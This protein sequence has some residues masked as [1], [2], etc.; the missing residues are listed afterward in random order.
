VFHAKVNAIA[1]SCSTDKKIFQNVLS[2]CWWER[3]FADLA[4]DHMAQKSRLR[5]HANK[6]VAR[7][8]SRTH[9]IDS[10]GHD[11]H[12]SRFMS[13]RPNPSTWQI[14]KTF[15][16]RSAITDT[17]GQQGVREQETLQYV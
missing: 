13:T 4:M 11:H 17:A 14:Y 9:E 16:Q 12:Q 2:I 5:K 15:I 8:A 6:L 7:R 3:F 10:F 1:F